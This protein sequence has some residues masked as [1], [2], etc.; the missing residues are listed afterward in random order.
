MMVLRKCIHVMIVTWNFLLN[1]TQVFTIKM[2]IKASTTIATYVTRSLRK[3]GG[4]RFHKNTVHG[5]MPKDW[6]CEFCEASF[7][8]KTFLLKHK[9]MREKAQI[10]DN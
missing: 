5:N 4:L 9:C 3:K 7:Y 1:L 2:F 6:K 8:T 10:N